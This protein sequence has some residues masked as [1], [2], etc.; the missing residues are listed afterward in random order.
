MFMF[1]VVK[2]FDRILDRLVILPIFP[3][4]YPR[5]QHRYLGYLG[6]ALLIFRDRAVAAVQSEV[7]HVADMWRDSAWWQTDRHTDTRQSGILIKNTQK[8]TPYTYTL[9]S[10][11][12]VPIKWMWQQFY[13]CLIMKCENIFVTFLVWHFSRLPICS[14]SDYP[15][16]R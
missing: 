5:L 16:P 10:R 4:S 11:C 1:K 15:D 2:L 7:Q 8:S 13:F 14:S 9:V 3:V 12:L 6:R